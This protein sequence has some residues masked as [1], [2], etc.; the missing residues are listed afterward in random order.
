MLG[1]YATVVKHSPDAVSA[2]RAGID[3]MIVIMMDANY[4]SERLP[5][6]KNEMSDL[7]GTNARY[8]NQKDH[9]P[10][11]KSASALRY[12]RLVE[13][14]LELTDMMNAVPSSGHLAYPPLFQNQAQARLKRMFTTS[15]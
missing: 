4:I 6:L 3:R 5:R 8:W 1:L 10:L 7:R 12:Y 13:I 2:P 9:T 15:N 11:Q 14:K